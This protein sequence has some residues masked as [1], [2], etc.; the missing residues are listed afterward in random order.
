M[1]YIIRQWKD[2]LAL[3]SGA[4]FNIT[5]TGFV[6]MMLVVQQTIFSFHTKFKAEKHEGV[7]DEQLRWMFREVNSVQLG[8]DLAWDIFISAGTFLFALGFWGHPVL[9]KIL[10]IAG[11]LVALLLLAF[12]LAYFPVPP[13]E[14]GSV[15]F[16]PFCCFMVSYSYHMDTG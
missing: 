4:L 14:A 11:M 8:I 1:F 7:S 13:A 10:S 3:R 15:D 6:T 16:G 12:N 2:S 5:A 9:N